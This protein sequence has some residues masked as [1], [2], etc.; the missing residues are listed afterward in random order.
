MFDGLSDSEQSC[1]RGALGDELGQ[2]LSQT[3]VSEDF[4]EGVETAVIPCL[5]AETANA[6]FASVMIVAF[7]QFVGELSEH[8]KSCVQEAFSSLDAAAAMASGEDVPDEVGAG[9]VACVAPYALYVRTLLGLSRSDLSEE[10]KSCSREV[11]SGPDV[12]AILASDEE[13]PEELIAEMISCVS[14]PSAEAGPPLSLDEYAAWCS[15]LSQVSENSA[16]EDITSAEVAEALA[17]AKVVSPPGQLS[18]WHARYV[19][20]LRALEGLLDSET[21][22]DSIFFLAIRPSSPGSRG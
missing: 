21:E 2:T 12:A 5:E 4:G 11:F 20:L 18:D 14:Q 7:Q 10:E 3:I 22:D 15:E 16:D 19:I 6:V 1:I 17:A 9:L 8:E 13:F